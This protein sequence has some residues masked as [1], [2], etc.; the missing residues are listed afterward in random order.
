MACARCVQRPSPRPCPAIITIGHC[1]AQHLL[2]DRC[3]C[4]PRKACKL[5]GCNEGPQVDT[6]GRVM[7]S[8]RDTQNDGGGVCKRANRAPQ[9]HTRIVTIKLV[10]SNASVGLARGYSRCDLYH[11]NIM[12]EQRHFEYCVDLSNGRQNVLCLESNRVSTPH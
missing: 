12:R 1:G 9:T 4:R 3:M 8:R 5:P 7:A 10:K 11:D 6:H 2:Q